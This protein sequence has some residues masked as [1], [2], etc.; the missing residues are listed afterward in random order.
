MQQLL[1][2]TPAAI[3]SAEAN[4]EYESVTYSISR[5]AL[6]NACS[7]VCCSNDDRNMLRD[8]DKEL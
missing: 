6:G 7:M 5:L 2:S 1:P 8:D 3:L 4:S